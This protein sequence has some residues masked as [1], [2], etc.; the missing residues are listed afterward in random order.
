MVSACRISVVLPAG[1]IHKWM[2]NP[3]YLSSLIGLWNVYSLSRS[4][5]LSTGTCMKMLTTAGSSRKSKPTVVALVLQPDP[6]F[7]RY[8]DKSVSSCKISET[9]ERKWSRYIYI[10]WLAVYFLHQPSLFGGQTKIIWFDLC[11]KQGITAFR[12]PQLSNI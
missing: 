7:T 3:F 5:H 4:I 8:F 6:A 2:T 9:L 10:Y 11:K 1:K 12:T